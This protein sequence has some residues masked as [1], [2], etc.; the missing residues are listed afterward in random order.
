M[1]A[2]ITETLPTSGNDEPPQL[3]EAD[4]LR[5]AREAVRDCLHEGSGDAPLSLNRDLQDSNQRPAQGRGN[6]R[7]GPSGS[8]LPPPIRGMPK[9][10]KNP[11]GVRAAEFQAEERDHFERERE[12]KDR[13]MR[14]ERNGNGDWYDYGD[15]QDYGHGDS[16]VGAQG[17]METYQANGYY[18]DEDDYGGSATEREY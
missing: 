8:N 14:G 15:D 11:V 18:E 1:M 9:R 5:I 3:T 7:N 12:R 6:Q 4:F 17:G 13:E 10:G 2:T 16:R